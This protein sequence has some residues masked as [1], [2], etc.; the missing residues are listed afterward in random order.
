MQVMAARRVE[1]MA[2]TKMIISIV[3]SSRGIRVVGLI[4]SKAS[5]FKL[6]AM[7]ITSAQARMSK[8]RKSKNFPILR[9]LTQ[10]LI[11]GQ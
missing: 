10:L 11:Q 7:K 4:T 2:L 6:K 1:K 5:V 8:Q 3:S 9:A